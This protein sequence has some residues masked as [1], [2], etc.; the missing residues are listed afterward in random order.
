MQTIELGLDFSRISTRARLAEGSYLVVQ[1]PEPM[2]QVWRWSDWVFDGAVGNAR[3]AGRWES[4]RVQRYLV[5]GISRQ[6]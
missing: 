3:P 1:V 6:D 2:A 5:L 4:D